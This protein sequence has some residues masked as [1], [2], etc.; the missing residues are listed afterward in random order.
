MTT[1]NVGEYSHVQIGNTHSICESLIY[2]WVR[3]QSCAL[4]REERTSQHS[5]IRDQENN[6]A[7]FNFLH[8]PHS[9]N[10]SQ[11]IVGAMLLLIMKN[12]VLLCTSGTL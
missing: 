12:F 9:N 10:P 5:P 8:L 6:N 2:S 4:G 11:N 1:Q 3:H 7:N